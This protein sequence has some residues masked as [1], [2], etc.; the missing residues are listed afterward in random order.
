[1]HVMAINGSPRKEKSSTFH[2]LAPL[3]EGMRAAGA[4]T[5]L[6]NLGQLQIKPC[7]GCFLCWVKTPGKCVQKDDM[8]A[9]L[10][11]FVQA[12]LVVFGT[13][14]YHYHMS[15]LMKNFI[16]RT[17][18]TYE[19]WL[20]KDPNHPERSGHP[21]RY[22]RDR[23]MLLISPC[24]FPEFDYFG[25]MVQYFQFFA[26]KLG[27][28]YMGEI[29]RPGGESLCDEQY[30]EMFGWYYNLVHQAGE[31]LIN[32]GLITPEVQAGLRQDLFPGGPEAFR[33]EANN[34]W[35]ATMAKFGLTGKPPGQ[36]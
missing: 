33:N 12:D 7:L 30:Q 23:G 22:P 4:T 31:Q 3:L 1:M 24:G 19:P 17:L 21:D 36:G 11:R 10:E 6:V 26:R 27:W 28:R 13:P 5:E 2:I 16:D 35:M 25:P 29:L 32:Q 15:G 14:L 20:V 34:Y 8:S 9:L 18:P